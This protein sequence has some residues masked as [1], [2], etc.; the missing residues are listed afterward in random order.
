M[1]LVSGFWAKLKRPI[2]AMAPMANVTDAAFRRMFAELGKPDVFWTEFV[3]VEGLLSAGREKLLVDLWYDKSEHP[4]VAQIFGGKP[5]QFE[6]IGAL[7]RGLGFDGIDINMGCP[8]RGVEKS[9]GGAAL[10]KDPARAKEII[11]AAKR[12]AGDLPVSV[13]TRLGYNKDES[14]KWLPALLEEGLAALTVH[15]R[16]RKEMSAVP[17]HWEIAPK[18]AALRNAISPGTVLI[19]NGDVPNTDEA[20]Q[21]AA[22]TGFD[23]VMIGRGAFGNP[24]LFSGRRP[25]IHERL[26]RLIKHA[27]LFEKLYKS[28]G[29]ERLKSFDLMKKHFKAYVSGF[30]E[31]KDLRMKLMEAE[32]A[33]DVRN[34]VRNFNAKETVI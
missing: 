34:I 25:D 33:A 24:W 4:I 19:G 22:E 20:R 12:G 6:K 16:T 5:E 14:V 29:P 18:I 28:N 7:I 27:E 32:N 30:D 17:A 11:R 23:G 10:I 2:M 8:D 9:G 15:L 21:R 26:E 13:K 3:S 31:A 1:E